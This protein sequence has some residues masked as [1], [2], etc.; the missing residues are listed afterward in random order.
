LGRGGDDATTAVAWWT[1]LAERLGLIDVVVRSGADVPSGFHPTRTA[2]LV[3]R[4]TGAV[5]GFVGEVDPQLVASLVPSV[6]NR[7]LGM[8][9]VDFDA[10][11]DP[12]RA[13]RRG[14]FVVMPSRYPSAVV[15]LA[16]VTPTSLHA[17]DLAHALRGAS[18][19]VEEV[20]LFDVYNGPN[21]APGTRSLAYTVRFS[22][23]ERT[24]SDEEVTGA[25]DALI[26]R[27]R[28]LGATLR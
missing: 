17:Q 19:L 7:R 1:T 14:E 8:V 13:T 12:S 23:N 3:D 21:L 9:D 6:V 16:L 2:A 18:P 15:D 24:L 26:H 25:R 28:G 11:A 4:A 5:L 22:S 20:T 10:L 27:A